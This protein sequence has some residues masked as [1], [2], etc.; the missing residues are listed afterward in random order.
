MPSAGGWRIDGWIRLDKIS[1][2]S[3]SLIRVGF[4]DLCTS[5]ISTS[6]G[7]KIRRLHVGKL[8]VR[9]R[10]GRLRL[11]LWL[12][13]QLLR[14]KTL[15]IYPGG[16]ALALLDSLNQAHAFASVQ[17]CQQLHGFVPPAVQVAADLIYGVVDVDT[18]GIVVPLVLDRQAHTVKQH[19]IKQTIP[20]YIQRIYG[21]G[22]PL[23]KATVKIYLTVQ[24]VGSRQ[25]SREL[26]HYSLQMIVA[27]SFK[28]NNQRAVQFRKWA[29]QIVKD[30]TI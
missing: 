17:L 11:L 4:R 19:P 30:H 25:V 24:T 16:F 15:D 9:R 23:P 10:R 28:V 22:E 18:P 5:K 3:F 6:W 20:Q 21:D 29:G 7:R 8:D 27:V 13:R 12:G 26:N 1:L 14:G 2:I